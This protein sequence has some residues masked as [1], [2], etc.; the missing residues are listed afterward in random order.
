MPHAVCIHFTLRGNKHTIHEPQVN[1][2]YQKW[3]KHVQKIGH[4]PRWTTMANE[5]TVSQAA[6]STDLS[7][8][9]LTIESF[10]PVTISWVF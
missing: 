3:R 9:T 8:K 5:D 4:I 6:I 2:P 1:Q 10:V 7:Q